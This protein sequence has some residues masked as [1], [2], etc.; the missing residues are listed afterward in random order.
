M[1]PASPGLRK[2]YLIGNGLAL[3]ITLLAGFVNLVVGPRNPAIF[4]V[5]LFQLVFASFVLFCWDS[6][7]LYPDDALPSFVRQLKGTPFEAWTRE[8]IWI[9]RL[10][11]L[12]FFCFTPA[13]FLLVSVVLFYAAIAGTINPL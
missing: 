4:L 6:I 2:A 10:V 8:L 11:P 1:T 5:V 12:G 3:V 13:F 9:L 7:S